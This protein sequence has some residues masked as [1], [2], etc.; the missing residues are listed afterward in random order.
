MR[1]PQ[2][3]SNIVTCEECDA[4]NDVMFYPP[5]PGQPDP[6]QSNP[7]PPEPAYHDPYQ[8]GECDAILVTE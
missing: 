4:D 5:D 1:K 6:E 2:P 3:V 7:C 8:C